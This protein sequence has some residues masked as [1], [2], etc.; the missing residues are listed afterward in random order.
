DHLRAAIEA[1]SA[2][3]DVRGYLMWTGFDNFE[4]LEGYSAHFGLIE[5]DRATLERRPKP[6][7]A[8]FSEICAARTLPDSAPVRPRA[9]G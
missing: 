7:A 9:A 5:V 3:V 1:S 4:W 2:G 6:S 8:L